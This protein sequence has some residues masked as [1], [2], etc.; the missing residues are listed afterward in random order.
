MYKIKFGEHTLHI[1]S[2]VC[3]FSFEKIGKNKAIIYNYTKSKKL[4]EILKNISNSPIKNHVVFH[5]DAE[6]VFEELSKRFTFIKAAGGLVLNEKKQILFILRNG[7]WDLPKGKIEAHETIELGA[8]RE[9]EEECGIKVSKLEKLLDITYHTYTLDN[10]YILKAN[11]WYIMF[12]DSAQK[13]IPQIEEN[14]ERVEWVDIDKTEPILK[15][16]YESI[17][18]LMIKYRTLNHS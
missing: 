4:D 16:S 11:Y 5:P 13:L 18:D 10:K 12:A 9:V 7:K 6:M 3:S 1:L 14:I 15:E 8:I 17:R 2:D